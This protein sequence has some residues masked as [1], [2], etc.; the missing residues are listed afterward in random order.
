MY[1]GSASSLVRVP[2]TSSPPDALSLLI[3]GS[4]ELPASTRERVK[5]TSPGW[6][7]PPSDAARAEVRA[8]ASLFEERA[9]TTLS[10]TAATEASLRARMGSASILHVAAPFRMNGASP[11]FSPILL[12]P[13]SVAPDPPADNDGVLEMREVMNL[14]LR[15]R[16]AVLSDGASASMRDAAPSADTVRWAWRASGVPSI[17]LSRWRVDDAAVTSMLK[18][19]YAR[20][21]DGE[22]PD[23]ALQG[24]RTAVRAAEATRAPYFWAGWMVVGR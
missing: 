19:L 3:V 8:I 18:E 20:L 12:S 22:A 15:A 13:D 2:P 9:V 6:T 16:V 23:T 17:V 24:A 7:L 14:D 1:A 5:A 10:G 4:P 21:K 11:L